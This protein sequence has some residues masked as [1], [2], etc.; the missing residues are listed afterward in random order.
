M[1]TRGVIALVLLG[2]ALIVV[3]V[4]DNG[5][6]ILTSV[7]LMCLGFALI[8]QFR[9]KKLSAATIPVAHS[10]QLRRDMRTMMSDAFD[11]SKAPEQGV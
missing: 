7:A 9:G 4:L 8:M 2:C 5:N 3:S 11:A 10:D 6:I 1:L